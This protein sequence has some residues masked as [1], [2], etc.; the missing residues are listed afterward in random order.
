MST[1]SR[2]ERL[3]YRLLITKRRRLLRALFMINNAVRGKYA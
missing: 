2:R 3:I 1:L